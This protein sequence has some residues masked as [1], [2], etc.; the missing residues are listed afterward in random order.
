VGPAKSVV[1][2][3]QAWRRISS[4]GSVFL[5]PLATTIADEGHSE[6]ERRWV[7]LGLSRTGLLL[8]VIHTFE[9]ADEGSAAVRI[10]S[11]RRATPAEMRDYEEGTL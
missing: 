9:E 11:A 7:T 1:Q 10:I 2:S 5:D 8:V 6:G 4:S 3:G